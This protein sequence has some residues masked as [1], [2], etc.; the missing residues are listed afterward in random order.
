M[1]PKN[2][3]NY[4]LFLLLFVIIIL[5]LFSL[6]KELIVRK[7]HLLVPGHQNLP[8]S[9]CSSSPVPAVLWFLIFLPSYTCSCELSH[10]PFESTPFFHTSVSSQAFLVTLH[11]H[12]DRFKS[13]WPDWIYRNLY[14]C[15]HGAASLPLIVTDELCQAQCYPT[16][17]WSCLQSGLQINKQPHVSACQMY[18]QT[19]H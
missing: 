14:M 10:F 4:S 11:T 8:L 2:P 18:F 7:F 5:L 9:L 6:R 17:K 19:S 12:D 13:V 1:P 16:L 15:A 3:F